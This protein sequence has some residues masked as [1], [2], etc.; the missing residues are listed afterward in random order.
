M[1][2]PVW[3]E[4]QLKLFSFFPIFIGYSK[5]VLTKIYFFTC[6]FFTICKQLNNIAFRGISNFSQRYHIWHITRTSSASFLFLSSSIPLLASFDWLCK[7]FSCFAK[8]LN[9]RSS[10]TLIENKID[11]GGKREVIELHKYTLVNNFCQI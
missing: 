9:K 10:Q 4:S 5:V 8:K 2:C 7:S 3:S 6:F 1:Y 11:G